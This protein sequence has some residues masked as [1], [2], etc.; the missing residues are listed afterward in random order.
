ML[1]IINLACSKHVFNLLRVSMCPCVC[2]VLVERVRTVAHAAG[3]I[4]HGR[5]HAR[6]A[7]R[8]MSRVYTQ[9]ATYATSSQRRRRFLSA[10]SL[11][12]VSSMKPC[13]RRQRRQRRW[14]QWQVFTVR[15]I[16]IST[17]H[18]CIYAGICDHSIH[19][20]SLHYHGLSNTNNL[21]HDYMPCCAES[22]SA[23]DTEKWN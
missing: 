1:A 17:V 21:V 16:Y 6:C 23:S 5:A 2:C 9:H 10:V 18:T 19:D 8:C 11:W 15:V 20:G 12:E 13:A 14:W 22:E 3:Q 7:V 4:N